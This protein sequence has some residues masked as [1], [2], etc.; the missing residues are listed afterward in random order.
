MRTIL[1]SLL[2][3]VLLSGCSIRQRVTFNSYVDFSEYTKSGFYVSPDP[4]P[5]NCDPIGMI[6]VVIYPGQNNDYYKT[7]E[8]LSEAEL[9]KMAVDQAKE[10]GANGLVNYSATVAPVQYQ[11]REGNRLITY[12]SRYVVRG[13]AVKTKH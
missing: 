9:L 1:F 8:V 3:V 11:V 13:L 10:K 6:E 7:D 5:G 12:K 2:T 4:Y